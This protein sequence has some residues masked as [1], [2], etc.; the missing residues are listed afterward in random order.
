M[1]GKKDT[2]GGE[3]QESLCLIT[4]LFPWMFFTWMYLYLDV[5]LLYVF[6]NKYIMSTI[7][8]FSVIVILSP[9]SPYK[10]VWS[11]DHWESEFHNLIY[12]P[13]L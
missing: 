2:F 5:S 1:E 12:N 10:L 11:W 3:R 7:A 6:Y 13:L 9:R 8:T 4:S